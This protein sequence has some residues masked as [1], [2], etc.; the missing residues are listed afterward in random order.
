MAGRT[1]QRWRF[2]LFNVE[3]SKKI[4]VRFSKLCLSDKLPPAIVF[5]K[6]ER[7]F[8]N[9][10]FDEVTFGPT[11]EIMSYIGKTAENI[12]FENVDVGDK[13]FCAI[14]RLLPKIHSLT[15]TRCSPLFMSGSFL[16]NDDD[17]LSLSLIFS[18]IRH[19]SLK[20]NQY[21][22]DAILLRITEMMDS[23]YSLDL[24]GCHIAYHNAIQ[25]RF[26]PN[27]FDIAPSESILTFRIILRIISMHHRTLRNLDLSSTLLGAPSL[28]ALSDLA[29]DG[30]QL[31]HLSLANCRQLNTISLQSFLKSQINL[32]TLDLSDTNCVNDSCIDVIVKNLP[33]IQEL[34]I[35]GCTN[36]SNVG[37]SYLGTLKY[38]KNLNISHCDG[39][40]SD[41]IKHGVAASKNV[42]LQYLQMAHLQVCVETVKTL[43]KNLP[44]LRVLNLG[45]CVNGVTDES[46]QSIIENLHWLRV[47]SLE[48]CFRITDAALTGI[49]I[50]QLSIARN[51]NNSLDS[52]NPI[53]VLSLAERET[54]NDSNMSIKISLRSKA[55]EEIVR[56]AHRKKAMFA[57][58]EMNLIEQCNV[59]GYN[60][61]KIRGLNT[62]NLNG[63]HKISD[64]SLKYGI[65]LPELRNL[66]LANCQ[67]I[68][69]IGFEQLVQDCPSIET[70]DLSDCESINDKAIQLVTSKLTRLRSL[71][72]SGCSQLTD[73][74]LDAI[75]INCKNLQTLSVHRCRSIYTDIEDRLA[76]MPT[77][78]NLKMDNMPNMDNVCLLRLK[79]RLDY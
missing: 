59:E 6:S 72:I 30:L 41:G 58:Y 64:V 65:K 16:D 73:H 3:I 1:C 68:S 54:I 75:L 51:S 5:I 8:R 60:I 17:R 26:Y 14:L 52:L 43:S 42:I 44:E 53:S 15:I 20:D 13:Q 57:A 23:I 11:E 25:R 50:S 45:H 4:L 76:Q 22:S 19:L 63:C 78:R 39:I 28:I 74:S 37:A 9:Y 49:N 70:L 31:Q 71:H 48:N 46:V 27:E 29:I 69:I 47:L 33:L 56:D 2:A 61:K 21:L 38:L 40:Q 36:I 35:G 66:S 77:L 32:S 67:Q 10:Y 34:N 79:K 24:S 62:L 7:H 18:N 55:E 12:V